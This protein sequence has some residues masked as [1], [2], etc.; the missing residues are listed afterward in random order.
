MV[1]QGSV[2]YFEDREAQ[3]REA[4]SR[5][6]SDAARKIHLDLAEEYAAKA[7]ELKGDPAQDN[8]AA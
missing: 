7:R 2:R 1:D 5:A 6:Q 8:E 4:A 3:E